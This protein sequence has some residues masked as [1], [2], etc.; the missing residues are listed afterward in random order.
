MGNARKFGDVG[1]RVWVVA[2]SAWG[3]KN[4]DEGILRK[5]GL[6]FLFSKG[7]FECRG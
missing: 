5:R 2:E 6:G 1:G 3:S 4:V 7:G